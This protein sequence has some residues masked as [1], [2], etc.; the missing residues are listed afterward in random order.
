METGDFQACLE[1]DFVGANARTRRIDARRGGRSRPRPARNRPPRLA[2][3]VLLYSFGGLRR[4]AGEESEPL[5]P[6]IAESELL[7][8]ERPAVSSSGQRYGAVLSWRTA[9]YTARR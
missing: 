5:P 8:G 9:E 7:G 3:V 2:T 1:H 6:R 4:S